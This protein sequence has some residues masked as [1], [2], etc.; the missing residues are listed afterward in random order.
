MGLPIKGSELDS[1]RW[2]EIFFSYLQNPERL[3][4]HPAFYPVDGGGFFLW[5]KAAGV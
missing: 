1:R 3:W 4:A 5:S 2:Q